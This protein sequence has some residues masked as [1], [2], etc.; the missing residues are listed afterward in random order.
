M[1]N[2]YEVLGV[3]QTA[4]SDEIKKAYRRL[5]LQYHPDRNS[6]PDAIK[7]FQKINDAHEILSDK[8]S[9]SEYDMQLKGI[10]NPFNK[11]GTEFG[12]LNN[13][14]NAFMSGM[15]GMPNVRVFNTGNHPGFSGHFAQQ[16][17]KPP[18]IIRNI[19]LTMEQSYTGGSFPIQIN[20][21]TLVNGIES[22]EIQ[23]LYISLPP[24]IDDNEMVILR[25]QG[26]Q[27]SENIKGDVK[28][29]I[30]IKNE[31]VF[32]RQ[33]LDLIYNKN[34]TL[35]E[36]LC[37]FSFDL[38]HINKKIFTFNNKINTTIIKPGQTKIIPQLG[39]TRETHTG[40]LIVKFDILF[41]DTIS[42][43]DMEKLG[44]IL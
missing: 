16:I 6:T 11:D 1:T 32:K 4:N 15:N 18:P 41:P 34:I 37:G 36:A 27:I 23:T 17:N 42:N 3:E 33:G 35:K 7:T 2:H 43:E 21:W 9:R 25:N 28:V 8:Q 26:H 39:M 10:G 22:E 24:G 12:D 29:N 44:E 20:K 40:N 14:F 31:T 13:I 30:K 19:E 5:S 38:K